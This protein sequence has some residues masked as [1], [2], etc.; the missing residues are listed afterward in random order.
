[1]KFDTIIIGGGLAGLTCGIRLQKAGQKCAIVSAG[2]SAMHFFSGSFDLL[3]R[4]PDGTEVRN[5]IED[6]DKLPEY[7]PYSVLGKEKVRKYAMEAPDFL[8]SCGIRT[9]GDC[10]RNTWRITPTGERKPSWL[11]VSDFTALDSKDEKIAEKALIVNISGYLDFNTSFLAESFESHGTR[12]RIESLKLE[13]ME[14]LRNNP[15]EM[16]ATNIARVMDRDEI[17]IKAAGFVR[18]MIKDE[19]LVVL[20]AVFGLKNAEITDR[21]REVTG[22]RTIFIATMPPSVPGIRSQMT[23]KAEFEK[24]GGRFLPGDTVIDA[25]RD[26]Y[27]RISSICTYN[28]GEIR[29]HADNF[30]LAS[31]SFFSKGLCASPD[32]IYEP[33]FGIDLNCSDDRAEWFDRSFWK[34]QNYISFGAITDNHLNASKEGKIIDNLYVI[35]SNLGGSNTLHEGCGG[36][37]ALITALTAAD[38]IIGKMEERR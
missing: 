35:G 36:G 1:M 15:S 37:I 30:V 21:I 2:Q 24:A 16:R 25:I 9:S 22:V 6:M 23:L 31:G 11:T 32:G 34:R 38:E 26:E 3:C 5:P 13:E 33:I 28:L 4:L 10:T 7:H 17:W 20:P 18:D 19:D 29:L 14:R 27:G 12:C 8:M